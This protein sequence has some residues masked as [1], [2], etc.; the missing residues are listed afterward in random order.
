[1]QKNHSSTKNDSVATE[2]PEMQDKKLTAGAGMFGFLTVSLLLTFTLCKFS[3]YLLKNHRSLVS[4]DD[5]TQTYAD[6]KSFDDNRDA[7]PLLTARGENVLTVQPPVNV[8]RP[9]ESALIASAEPSPAL[10]K[11]QRMAPA[12]VTPILTAA[13]ISGTSLDDISEKEISSLLTESTALLDETDKSLD[14]GKQVLT[15]N[16]VPLDV[17]ANA[18]AVSAKND[19]PAAPEPAKEQKPAAVVAATRQKTIE[20][21]THWIDMAALRRQIKEKKNVIVAGTSAPSVAS[22][23]EIPQ[24]A[25]LPETSTSDTVSAPAPQQPA[26]TKTE[27]KN[28]TPEGPAKQTAATAVTEKKKSVPPLKAEKTYTSPWKVAKVNGTNRLN[29]AVTANAEETAAATII[30]NK[31]E[32]PAQAPVET[33]STDETLPPETRAVFYHNGKIKKIITKD[34]QAVDPS[35][36]PEEVPDDFFAG[37]EAAV[38]TNMSQSDTPSV[39]SFASGGKNGKTAKAFK[40]ADMAPP[41]LGEEA[42]VTT[43]QPAAAAEEKKEAATAAAPAEEKAAQPAKNEPEP[44]AKPAAAHPS[45]LLGLP[46]MDAVPVGTKKAGPLLSDM[47]PKD[48]EPA[49]EPKTA[50]EPKKTTGTERTNEK[51]LTSKLFSMFSNDADKKTDADGNKEQSAAAASNLPSFPMN[52]GG[53]KQADVKPL[54]RKNVAALLKNLSEQDKTQEEDVPAPD[55]I[56]LTF[57]PQSTDLSAASVKLIRKFA[58]RAQNDIQKRI[59]VRISQAD[60]AIQV[61]RLAIIRNIITGEGVADEQIVVLKTDRSPETMVL[62]T[63]VIRDEAYETQ[64]SWLNGKEERLY[65]RKW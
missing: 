35:A 15:E 46:G 47:G 14:D 34:G 7:A 23:P 62:R 60:P 58:S 45:P 50:E 55:E 28:A 17:P 31:K 22:M 39:W 61:Q 32:L 21:G 25:A 38:W 40:V 64:A 48:D 30:E 20:N 36:K 49:E 18:V 4:R 26:L 24:T 19:L 65:Y 56:R 11:I 44:A 43:V 3:F 27:K 52:K 37:Q 42:E 2:K 54:A 13:V 41:V 57:K 53:V 63:F 8:K 33:V 12:D 1:M 6:L 51:S 59:E 29:P 16:D 5:L 9:D 10:L